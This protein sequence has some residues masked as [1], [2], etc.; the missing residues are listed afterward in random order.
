MPRHSLMDLRLQVIPGL[1]K[2]IAWYIREGN[3]LAS[4]K[5]LGLAWHLHPPFAEGR[6]H[7]NEPMSL[8]GHCRNTLNDLTLSTSLDG[9]PII[10]EIS[11]TGNLQYTHLCD[12]H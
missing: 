12:P 3:F 1:D 6:P 7:F 11:D 8:L 10:N 9:G 5:K 2:L 4:L